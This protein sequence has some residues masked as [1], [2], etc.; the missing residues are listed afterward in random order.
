MTGDFVGPERAPLWLGPFGTTRPPERPD[1]AGSLARVRVDP[2]YYHEKAG[3]TRELA[4]RAADRGM[5][6]YLLKVAER[7]DQ[8]ATEEE[9][10]D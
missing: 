9:Q 6:D 10:R 7:Y 4:R 5:R 2:K 8:L 3:Q 1:V